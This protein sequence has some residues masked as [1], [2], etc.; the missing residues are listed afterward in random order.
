MVVMVTV[1]VRDA[2]MCSRVF[3]QS[4]YMCFFCTSF[5]AMYKQGFSRLRISFMTAL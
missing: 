3:I 5:C 1:V 4:R 2:P